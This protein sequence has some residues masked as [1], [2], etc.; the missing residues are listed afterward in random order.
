MSAQKSLQEYSVDEIVAWDESAWEQH[1]Q[2]CSTSQ[3]EPKSIELRVIDAMLGNIL[4]SA[5]ATFGIVG[6]VMAASLLIG[7]ILFGFAHPL[8]IVLSILAGL[9]TVFA[10]RDYVLS[11]IDEL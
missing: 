3:K 8:T 7:T 5:I 10:W 2:N 9:I 11:R 6:G 1:D 4:L